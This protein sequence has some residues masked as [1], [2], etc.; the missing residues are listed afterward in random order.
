MKKLHAR[1]VREHGDH[2][3]TSYD[4]AE[5]A[6]AAEDALGAFSFTLAQV[7]TAV[8]LLLL[9][10]NAREALAAAVRM[11]RGGANAWAAA[12]GRVGRMGSRRRRGADIFSSDLW[13]RASSCGRPPI[14]RIHSSGSFCASMRMYVRLSVGSARWRVREV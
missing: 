11:R 6:G 1:R 3:P 10:E 7:L 4:L 12:V 2:L 8:W 9:A 14:R 5:P 13:V